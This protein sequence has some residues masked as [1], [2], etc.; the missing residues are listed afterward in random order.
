MG[1]RGGLHQ[2]LTLSLTAIRFRC[3]AY[4]YIL[5]CTYDVRTN[6]VR[7]FVER[8]GM[9]HHN[10]RF[11]EPRA[12]NKLPIR[13]HCPWESNRRA[14]STMLQTVIRDSG[15]VL[16][17]TCQT[18]TSMD[19]MEVFQQATDASRTK[20]RRASGV[21]PRRLWGTD[22][23]GC[24]SFPKKKDEEKFS[25]DGGVQSFSRLS[26]LN[27]K[28]LILIM[29]LA[30]ACCCASYPAPHLTRRRDGSVSLV[31]H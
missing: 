11:R 21:H 30:F 16:E 22:G 19:E 10:R 20:R 9:D 7:E 18:W 5:L 23:A 31:S 26:L 29:D 15:T 28:C 12:V 3:T 6:E 1:H 4:P 13:S 27:P 25:T 8:Y 2:I 17:W 14:S 24:V